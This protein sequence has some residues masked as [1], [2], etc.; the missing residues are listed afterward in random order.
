MHAFALSSVIRIEMY[1]LKRK[2]MK[3]LK[4]VLLMLLL[5]LASSGN[6]QD[7]KWEHSINVGIGV[8]LD[9]V[10]QLRFVLLIKQVQGLT[11]TS[12]APA[13]QFCCI[14]FCISLFHI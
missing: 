8:A 6:A 4:L 5:T 1:D 7:K 3:Q 12:P 9:N 10:K 11:F 13:Y 14:H 2:Q